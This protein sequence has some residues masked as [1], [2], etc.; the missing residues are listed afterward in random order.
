MVDLLKMEGEG[1][2]EVLNSVKVKVVGVGEVLNLVKVKVVVG[3]GELINSLK[4]MV[5][6]G[7]VWH[8]VMVMV[9][10]EEVVWMA[11]M[12]GELQSVV[13]GEEGTMV[14]LVLVE[15]KKLMHSAWNL[16][17]ERCPG[18]E[19]GKNHWR[20]LRDSCSSKWRKPRESVN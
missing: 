4:V 7:E 2:E 19:I 3:E 17:T 16:Q 12:N 10:G 9:A 8:P 5:R 15:W 1:V 14:V 20:Y 6:E 11:R 13:I 18:T